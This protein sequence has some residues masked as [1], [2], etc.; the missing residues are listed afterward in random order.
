[1]Q[2]KQSKQTIDREAYLNGR[3]DSLR[4]SGRIPD[5]LKMGEEFAATSSPKMLH[6]FPR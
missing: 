6:D 3:K 2:K 5:A 4:F 1:M